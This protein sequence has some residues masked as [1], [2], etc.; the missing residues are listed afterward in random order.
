MTESTIEILS[1]K[2][3]THEHKEVNLLVDQL[4]S[5]VIESRDVITKCI[6]SKFNFLELPSSIQ[7]YLW[8]YLNLY[9]TPLIHY[10]LLLELWEDSKEIEQITSHISSIKE[11]L[12]LLLESVS[13]YT[14]K[15]LR[16]IELEYRKWEL[17][18]SVVLLKSAE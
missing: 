4:Q 1:E 7:H 17:N 5:L 6:S 2:I 9:S 11:A 13:L 14:E 18:K 12:L 15:D 3:R 8:N 10:S 16:S